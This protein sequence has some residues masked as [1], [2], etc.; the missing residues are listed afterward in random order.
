MIY[1]W[2]ELRIKIL[3]EINHTFKIHANFVCLGDP[4]DIIALSCDGIRSNIC[5]DEYTRENKMKGI[6]K[7]IYFG[8]KHNVQLIA[9]RQVCWK[10][11]KRSSHLLKDVIFA[12]K[13]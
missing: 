11:K 2:Y 8:G 3:F 12:F 5:F 9:H 7:L 6:H 4:E 1:S 13:L 10:F